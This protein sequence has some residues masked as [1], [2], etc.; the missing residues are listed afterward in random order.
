MP[1]STADPLLYR[2]NEVAD[3]LGLGMSKVY[4]LIRAGQ[5]RAVRVGGTIRIP[6]E[7]LERYIAALPSV[8]PD[9]DDDPEE[10]AALL[11]TRASR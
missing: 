3:M 8:V 11:T 10:E 1:L 6:R 4:Q 9:S 5:L 2:V 7:S